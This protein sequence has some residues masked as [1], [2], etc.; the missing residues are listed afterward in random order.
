MLLNTVCK[1]SL[2]PKVPFATNPLKDSFAWEEVSFCSLVV[3]CSG[4]WSDQW[5]I[6]K[7]K[8]AVLPFTP[9]HF[10]GAERKYTWI[11]HWQVA[12]E[13]KTQTEPGL[14]RPVQAPALP[15]EL[16]QVPFTP[17]RLFH[18]IVKNGRI[19]RALQGLL[20]I[21]HGVHQMLSQVLTYSSCSVYGGLTC[22][23]WRK[24]FGRIYAKC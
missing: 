14:E 20:R 15:L 22:V 23:H 21:R 16:W 7:E 17:L 13:G 9:F 3:L 11:T 18:N 4:Q 10:P 5:E 6:W 8:G 24:R 19:I 2:V 12:W 1:I